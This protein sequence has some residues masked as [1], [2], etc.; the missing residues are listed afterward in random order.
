M[1]LVLLLQ[2]TDVF[3]QPTELLKLKQQRH[4]DIRTE[5]RTGMK[6]AHGKQRLPRQTRVSHGQHCLASVCLDSAGVAI[7]NGSFGFYFF[8]LWIDPWGHF[9]WDARHIGRP[10]DIPGVPR[11]PSA[12]HMG[13]A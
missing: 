12:S 6:Y 13:R 5:E 9:T 1:A 7:R 2:R 10:W 4:C 11:A 3:F 8:Y